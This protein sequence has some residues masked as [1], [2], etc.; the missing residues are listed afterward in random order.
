MTI[1]DEQLKSIIYQ[2]EEIEL[3]N[4]RIPELINNVGH[5]LDIE[6]NIQFEYDLEDYEY[7]TNIK[8]IYNIELVDGEL[9]SYDLTDYQKDLIQKFLDNHLKGMEYYGNSKLLAV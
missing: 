5:S 1:T 2:S 6:C 3:V 9:N 4:Y 7:K 8:E